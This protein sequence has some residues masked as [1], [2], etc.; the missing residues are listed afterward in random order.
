MP[1]WPDTKLTATQKPDFPAAWTL[2]KTSI[3]LTG[4][5][6]LA[7]R[8]RATSSFDQHMDTWLRPSSFLYGLLLKEWAQ[9][10]EHSAFTPVWIQFSA[11]N[12]VG[13]QAGLLGWLVSHLEERNICFHASTLAM[14][15]LGPFQSFRNILLNPLSFSSLIKNLLFLPMIASSL[16]KSLPGTQTKPDWTYPGSGTSKSHSKPPS[17]AQGEARRTRMTTQDQAGNGDCCQLVLSLSPVA[18]V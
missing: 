6:S 10:P 1:P 4:L 5:G 14:F 9:Q 13:T 18:Q 12:W 8:W 16:L 15:I 7:Q 2:G 3:L 11:S 17:D